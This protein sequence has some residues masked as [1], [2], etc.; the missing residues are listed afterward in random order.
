[1]WSICTIIIIKKNFSVFFDVTL[2]YFF[3]NCGCLAVS[4]SVLSFH[5]WAMKRKILALL[6]QQQRHKS[7]FST[8]WSPAAEW[9]LP[10]PVWLLFLFTTATWFHLTSLLQLGR[11]TTTSTLRS[12]VLSACLFFS[13]CSASSHPCWKEAEV[14]LLH[15]QI[16]LHCLHP[17]PMK[18]LWHFSDY[19]LHVFCCGFHLIELFAASSV[20]PFIGYLQTGLIDLPLFLQ[21]WTLF[22]FFKQQSQLFRLQVW[23]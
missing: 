6:F 23:S 11:Q 5:R 14:W 7:S 21:L 4:F 20:S 9:T 12:S 3:F 22:L 10:W 8:P 15:S 16:L 18:S 17:P 19:N 2:N 13:P 1:M